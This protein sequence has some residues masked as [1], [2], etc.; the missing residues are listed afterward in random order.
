MPSITIGQEFFSKAKN[1][2]NNWRWALV[3]EFNQNGMDCGSK[4]I[5]W[6][7]EEDPN[8]GVGVTRVTVENDGDPM[9]REI[10]VDKLLSLGSSGKDFGGENTGGFGK[11]KEILYFC[12]EGGW[13]IHTGDLCVAGS[14]GDYDFEDNGH[15]DG[16][17]S[18]IWLEGHVA[19]ELKKEFER[20]AFYAQ[21]SGT[22][23]W[24]GA[25]YECNMRKGSPRRDLGFGQVYTNKQAEY[26]L[27]VRMNG[28]PM[29]VQP[30]SLDR[31]VVVELAGRSGDVLTSNRDGLTW[32]HRSAL[33][34]FITE[35]AV[36]KRSALKA[37][38]PKYR[39]YDGTRLC[40]RRAG[41]GVATSAIL[42][43]NGHEDPVEDPV[44]GIIEEGESLPQ[45]S[46]GAREDGVDRP[47]LKAAAYTTSEC[48]VARVAIGEEFVIKN[49]TEL[50]IPA[51][52][53]PDRSDFSSYSKK[54]ARI[55]GRLLLQLHRT[56]DH[57]ASFAIGWIFTDECEAEFEDGKF[58]KVYY[59]GPAR[60]VEQ[61]SSYS[62]SWKKRFALTER[63]RL[64]SLALHEFVHGLGYDVH[65]E[66][67]AGKITDMFG[68]V[69]DNRKDFNW[70]W[71]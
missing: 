66:S 61:S 71:R 45:S 37:R 6:T 64:L 59:L 51:Y 12:H 20:F 49:E 23:Y 13:E 65:D 41:S 70:C 14:G 11:A 8:A 16:T 25:P 40:H 42:G 48:E 3:R 36:D 21:W 17:R 57:E 15:V 10:L 29:F 43:M 47:S 53:L 67:Y 28:Q 22:L 18:T 50:A 68:V 35:I 52:Y 34:T 4:N 38:R 56:F 54:L 44:L 33:S 1:D 62:K 39:H 58:G 9:T 69:M 26:N 27:V 32:E 19:D 31:C 60:V 24:N 46:G 55:W 7:V 30:C 5:H 63:N 2:Y